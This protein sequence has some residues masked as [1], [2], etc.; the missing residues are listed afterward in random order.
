MT[1]LG[2]GRHRSPVWS[3]VPPAPPGVPSL[4]PVL[5]PWGALAPRP[6]GCRWPAVWRRLGDAHR[7]RVP[8]GHGGMIHVKRG[9]CASAVASD[10]RHPRGRPPWGPPWSRP[11]SLWLSSADRPSPAACCSLGPP[12]TAQGEITAV[13]DQRTDPARLRLPA[14]DAVRGTRCAWPCA[15]PGV[16]AGLL[17]SSRC[18]IGAF[19]GLWASAT[20]SEPARTAPESCA[21][22]CAPAGSGGTFDPIPRPPP[23]AD[24][25][26]PTAGPARDV[27]LSGCPSS[28]TEPV[29]GP[30]FLVRRDLRRAPDAEAA[31]PLGRCAT[32]FH[33]ERR[34]HGHVVPRGTRPARARHSSRSPARVAPHEARRAAW[35]S[36]PTL[37]L[38]RAGEPCLATERWGYRDSAPARPA[39]TGA[40]LSTRHHGRERAARPEHADSGRPSVKGRRGVSIWPAFDPA[41]TAPFI[42]PTF[43][44]NCGLRRA[45]DRARVPCARRRL[46]V[47][48]GARRVCRSTWNVTRAESPR[49]TWNGTRAQSPCHVHHGPWRRPRHDEIAPRMCVHLITTRGR[50]LSAPATPWRARSTWNTGRAML[51]KPAACPLG[52]PGQPGADQPSPTRVPVP[53]RGGRSAVQGL[54]RTG[55]ENRSPRRRDPRGTCC[56]REPKMSGDAEDLA[57][58]PVAVRACRCTG[59]ARCPHAPGH[60]RLTTSHRAVPQPIGHLGGASAR[61]C[62][63]RAATVHRPIVMRSGPG[64][65]GRAC[66][67]RRP[68]PPVSRT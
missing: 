23:T 60:R 17:L 13:R 15:R 40:S 51:P 47:E 5:L 35:L 58:R 38:R 30:R 31:L 1:V 59:R 49:S 37:R 50:I 27:S 25:A 12:P 67:Q 22:V 65:R 55:P 19:T 56:M 34:W 57:L 54:T 53:A 14:V 2:R 21:V 4:R 16:K 43:P 24:P 63:G 26:R 29:A 68:P 32:S 36:R 61:R 41:C 33:V 20:A 9:T 66:P 46:C 3:P 64:H 28:C 45:L 8:V 39:P 18:L 7:C 11:S 44:I 10:T 62:R 52:G 42:R 6:E 48:R